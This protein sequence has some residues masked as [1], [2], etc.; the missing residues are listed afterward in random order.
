MPLRPMSREQ[1]WLLPP[2]LGDLVPLTHPARFVAEFVDGLKLEEWA[3]LGVEV[4]GDPEGAPAYHPRALLG[5]WVYGF[6][7]GVRSCR[8]LEGACRD[9]VPYLWL[10]GW[11]HPDHNTL[12]RFY[13]QHRGA[14]RR[15]LKKTVRT[16]VVMGLVDLAVQAVDGTKISG[17]ASKQR[18]YNAKELRGLLERTEA[19]IAQLEAQNEGGEGPPLPQLPQE[20]TKAQTLR[21]R[22]RAA[23]LQ[24]ESEGEPEE[25]NLTDGDAKLMKTRH[26]FVAGYNAQAVVSPLDP[27][28]AGRPGLFIMAAEVVTDAEDHG[29]LL[30]M[31]EAAQEGSGVSVAVTLADA[32]YHSGAN[33]QTC[34][35]QGRTIVMPESG[36]ES[37]KNP[38]HKQRFT[39]GTESDD[40][41]CPH[42]QKLLFRGVK[43][44]LGELPVR[45]Y[46]GNGVV[47][48]ACPAFG[49]CTPNRQGRAIE[50]GPYEAVLRQHRTWMATQDAKALYCQRKVLPEPTFGILKEQ[51]GARRFLLRGLPNV[52]A[53]WHLLASAFNLRTLW[54]VWA[55]QGSRQSWW[56]MA[57]A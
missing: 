38:Y 46:R 11:Q 2:M 16:A 40:F 15:L 41:T 32:G 24:L 21:E 3:A 6:M 7:T 31:V 13:Q 9:Q 27:E 25:V 51:Q 33:L 19:A 50:T 48:R 22:V 28:Q 26:G 29:Q 39:Y 44:R 42:G 55:N 56:A 54:K 53:E 4:E 8:K 49:T 23:L 18:T 30:P 14:M 35:D 20:M 5:V 10:T 36:Q 43:K 47:C 17:S 45:V 12:W 57:R 1:G 52:S 34:A 37:L